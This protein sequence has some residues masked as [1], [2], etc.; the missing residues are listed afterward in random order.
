MK[1][2]D[3]LEIELRFV[4]TQMDSEKARANERIN[5]MRAAILD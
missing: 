1:Q 3:D 2:R 4:I 5:K